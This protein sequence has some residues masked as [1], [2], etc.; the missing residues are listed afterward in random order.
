MAKGY[1]RQQ[2]R[3]GLLNA[4]G[5]DLV[6]RSRSKCELCESSGSKLQAF[7]VEPLSPEPEVDRCIFICQKCKDELTQV[8]LL[9]L[10]HWK[11]LYNSIW[12]D[13][14][15]VQVMTLRLLKKIAQK[16]HWAQELIEQVYL[17][18]EMMEW[19]DEVDM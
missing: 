19:V 10:G 12:S 8:R 16:E 3:R 7:E 18:D 14:P 13:V 1:Q 2:Q 9:D 6:R 4:F 17:E 11:C 5:K 15:A